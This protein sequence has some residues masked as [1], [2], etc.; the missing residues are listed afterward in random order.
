[1]G[2]ASNM[3][4]R[5]EGGAFQTDLMP[6]PCQS[7]NACFW[8][9]YQACPLTSCCAQYS[10]R[11]KVIGGDMNKYRF[12]QNQFPHMEHC[13]PLPRSCER[14]NPEFALCCES[15]CCNGCAV[16]AS[17]LLIMDRYN[18]RSGPQ[19]NQC[20]RCTNLVNAV[21]CI[22]DT[23][24]WCHPCCRQAALLTTSLANLL[25]HMA[26]GCMTAQVVHEMDWR[27]GGIGISRV[28]AVDAS[29]A[30][31]YHNVPSTE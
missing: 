9:L 22:C 5:L 18:L 4:Y 2:H 16:S 12:Y 11:Y 25:Y 28:P 15:M 17:R 20:I 31:S 26:S 14:T 6:A 1:M 3:V 19:D 10:L 27:E 29:A 7:R 24:A 21:A 30:G 23:C 13:T 8:F